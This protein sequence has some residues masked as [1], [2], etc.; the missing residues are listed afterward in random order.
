M[1]VLRLEQASLDQLC[2]VFVNAS[3][4]LN[5]LFFAPPAAEL[6]PVWRAAAACLQ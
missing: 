4:A 6:L 5:P 3:S 1:L 2:D